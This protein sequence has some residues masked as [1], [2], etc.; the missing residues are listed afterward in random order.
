MQTARQTYACHCRDCQTWSGSAFAEHFMIPESLLTVSG[1]LAQWTHE[2]QS[3]VRSV[4]QS[5]ATCH[6]R[7]FNTTSAAPGLAVV[8]AGALAQS[9]RL[10]PIAHIWTSRKQPWITIPE[11]TPSWPQTP[12]PEAFAAAVAQAA[13]P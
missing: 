10:T 2:S 4:Q 1:P 5:C 9:D 11:G 6:T 7:I 8:R 12:A 3:G 13:Q